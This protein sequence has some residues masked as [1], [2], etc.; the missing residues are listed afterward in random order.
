MHARPSHVRVPVLPANVPEGQS[1]QPQSATAGRF[2][3]EPGAHGVPRHAVEPCASVYVPGTHGV[4]TANHP[5]GAAVT[6]N[7]PGAQM[8]PRHAVSPTSANVPGRHAVHVA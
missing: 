3:Y 2:E 7:V 6:P 1:V 8:V 5:L 4:H